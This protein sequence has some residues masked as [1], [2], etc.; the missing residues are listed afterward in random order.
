MSDHNK[1]LF[2][3]G[4][5]H[6]TGTKIHGVAIHPT[7]TNHKKDKDTAWQA[8]RKYLGERLKNA[9]PTLVGKPILLNHDEKQVVGTITLAR[10]DETQNG[11]FYEGTI[12]MQAADMIRNSTVKSVSVGVNPWI[13]GGGVEWL[14]GLAPYGFEFFELS[15]LDDRI[16]APGDPNAWVTLCEGLQK[17]R[18]EIREGIAKEKQDALIAQLEKQVPAEF[19]KNPPQAQEAETP[20]ATEETVKPPRELTALEKFRQRRMKA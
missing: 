18:A 16:M 20:E 8:E 7:T 6:V 9:T 11:V 2:L 12:T 14:D 13:K 5:A 4:Q 19:L 1:F 3:E 15:L 10:W 17:K